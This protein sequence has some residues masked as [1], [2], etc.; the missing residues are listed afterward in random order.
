MA[1]EVFTRTAVRVDEPHVSFVPDGRMALNAA[2]ARLLTGAG[3]RSVLLLWDSSNSRVALKAAAK[4]DKNSYA[5]S[6]ARDSH[7]GTLRA[8]AF[9]GYIGWVA[10]TRKMLPATWSEKDKMFEV[11]IPRECVKSATNKDAKQKAN[12]A[13]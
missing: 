10:R 4:T 11:K 3:V 9:F 12:V 6:I 5:V 2:A 1:Y 7:S 8:K 13:Q